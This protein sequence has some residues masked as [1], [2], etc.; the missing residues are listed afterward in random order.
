[1]AEEIEI[2]NV[3]GANGVAS[4]ATLKALVDALNKK[5]GSGAS[6]KAAKQYNDQLKNG[7]TVTRDNNKA[8]KTNTKATISASEATNKFAAKLGGAALGAIGAIAGSIGNLGK[9][10]I[11]GGSQLGDF[12][13][14]LPLVG[15]AISPLVGL[16]DDSVSSFRALSSVGASFG[17]SITDMRLA[18]ANAGLS[19]EEFSG[20]VGS[21]SETLRLLGGTV[22]QGTQRFLQ[23]NRNLK[24]TG[25]FETLKNL[26]F[27]V[28]DINEGMVDYI[29]LQ[30]N[31]GRG[32]KRS[33]ASLAQGSSQYL[34]QLDALAK[35]TGKSRK[36]LAATLNKQSQDAGFRALMNQ[37]E[38]GSEKAENF[39]ASMALID[40]LPAE[41]A[42]GLKDLADGVAQTPEA[43]AL[44]NA[45]GPEIASAMEAVADGADPQVIIDALGKAGVDM[46]KFA[47]L[48]GKQRAAF[49]DNLRQT[50]PT[51]AAILDSS[52]QLTKLGSAEFKKA[53]GEQKKRDEIT[54][55]LTTFDDSVREVRSKLAKAFIESGLFEAISG[56]TGN[57][58]DGLAAAV[59]HI[60][61]FLKEFT[62]IAQG[63]GF[64]AA[65][66]QK[67]IDPMKEALLNGIKGLWTDSSI[68]SKM[69]VGIL[70]L[71]A[72]AKVVGALTSGLGKL[73]GVGGGGGGVGGMP[74]KG[75]GA[76]AGKGAGAFVGNVTGGAMTGAARGLSAF[77]SPQVAIG[78]GVLAGTILVVG[79]AVAGATW[80]I[81]KSLPTFAEGLTKFEE[82]D[83]EKLKSAGLG[84]LSIGAGFAAFG[85]GGVAAGIGG[86]IGSISEG[87]L[88]M[89]GGDDPLTKIKKFGDADIDAVKVK[90]NAEAMV[91][92]GE[93]MSAA[94]VGNAAAGAGG[95]VGAF[96]SFFAD[97]PTEQVKEFGKLDINSEGVTNNAN[98]MLV[99]SQGIAA[100][101]NAGVSSLK[102]D[103]GLINN[104]STLSKIGP[105]LST[106]GD[107]IVKIAGVADLSGNV[108][109]LNSI[110]RSGIRNYNIEL[111]KMVDLLE[112]MNSELS[113][114]NKFGFGNGT[115]AGDVMQTMAD[116]GQATTQLSTTMLTTLEDIRDI[117]KASKALL[118][119][120][121][122]NI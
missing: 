12:T 11:N 93:A 35:V 71:F 17:N 9:E 122:R 3:G 83:G 65:I 23:M 101:A 103:D 18:S 29:D 7:A 77:A 64:G 74:G 73:F 2:S 98:A 15:Q 50:N 33:A 8:T 44:I 34:Q 96:A 108:N 66:S 78:A 94:G 14:H 62:T 39:A 106:A 87:L 31:L 19:M 102:I 59:P 97:D 91:A 48:E 28:M 57:L 90:A 61:K 111:A 16:I 27:T 85:V 119:E 47:G 88:G 100:M 68:F 110:D 95:I 89:F 42:T 38:A 1:V 51:L 55:S 84:M 105:G 21:N 70:G 5:D 40:T 109:L 25:D 116:S 80:M 13:Q 104:F 6:G 32:Q 120:I 115:N 75:K 72:G 92:F 43:V 117:N 99:M 10:F 37:F 63:E 113:K 4:E 118:G 81:G 26:G 107:A 56:Q 86:I 30:A 58:A 60:V 79:G 22:S 36:E 46:E 69:A 82:L 24:D 114:D 67:I 41:V 76:A 54:K 53:Q 49:I 20:L 45:A 52:T 112:D 121:K